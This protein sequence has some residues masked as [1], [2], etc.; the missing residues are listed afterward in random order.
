MAIVFCKEKLLATRE[1]IYGKEVLSC[2]KGHIEIEESHMDTAIRECYEET[3]VII[4]KDDYLLECESFF[5]KF[6]DHHNDLVK[7]IIYPLVFKID[8]LRKFYIKEER[9]LSIEYWNINDFLENCT[10]DNVKQI[11]VQAWNKII[12]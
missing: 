12:N 8:D 4:N 2:P 5:V 3:G 7:K 10:Y 11:I 6:I 1:L 9:I